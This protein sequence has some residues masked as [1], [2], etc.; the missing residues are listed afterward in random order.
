VRQQ[1]ERNNSWSAFQELPLCKR[2]IDKQVD[3]VTRVD[4]GRSGGVYDFVLGGIK[5]WDNATQRSGDQTRRAAEY[6]A[7]TEGM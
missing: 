3:V 1:L 5:P 7:V 4:F 6:T 2:Y